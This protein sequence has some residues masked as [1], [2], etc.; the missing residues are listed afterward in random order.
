MSILTKAAQ[1][2]SRLRHGTPRFQGGFL[3][4]TRFDYRAEVGDGLDA[5][6]VM[7]PVAW[8]QRALPEATL[9]VR[10]KTRDGSVA[11]PDHPLIALIQTPN[12]HY[13]DIALW[14]GTIL[15]LLTDGNAYWMI[16]RNGAG[17]P[18]E[19]WYI[20]HWMIE[21]KWLVDG[22]EFISHYRYAPGGGAEPVAVSIDDVVH[23]RL[24]LNPRNMRKGLSPI[25]SVVREIFMDIESS[26]FVASLLRNMGV[27]GVV[28]SPKGGAMPTPDDV[29]A[30]KAWFAEQ[31]G[32]DKRGAPLVMGAPT[33]VSPFGFNPQQMNMGEARDIAEERVCALLGIPSAVVGFGAGLQSTKVGATMTE[34]RKLA[35]NN[36]VLPV[37]KAIADE[38]KRAML[39]QFGP[40]SMLEVVWDVSQVAALQED[41]AA[42]TTMWNTRVQGGWATIAQAKAACGMEVEPGDHIYLRPIAMIEVPASGVRPQPPVA[43]PKRIKDLDGMPHDHGPRATPEQ[44]RRGSAYA[45]ILQR[46]QAGQ[47]RAW[48]KPLTTL[49]ARIG[50]EAGA[51]FSGEQKDDADEGVVEAILSRLGIARWAG[52]LRSIYE[53]QYIE[54]AK[55]VSEAAASAGLGASLP[56]EV[57]RAIIA[58]GGRRAELVDIEGQSRE[59]LFE[60]LA[61]GRAAGEGAEQLA[62]RIVERVEGGPWSTSEIRARVIARTE[63]KYAQN[64]STIE[65]ARA[66]G[67]EKFMVFDGRLGPGRSKPDHIARNGSIVTADEADKMAAAEHPNGTL[68]FAP[69]FDDE[70]DA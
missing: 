67:V 9:T 47:A 8:V 61:E 17:R 20:P 48:E 70:D 28:I 10:R 15:S 4:R 43:E 68:S 39:W 14:W 2:L 31:F 37:A 5:S 30:T 18:A 21:P 45:L 60:A 35:W 54:I 26:N 13:G 58:A 22:S 55:A 46:A 56:D 19:L 53:A 7:A 65:R 64:V 41:E 34:M 69:Y 27:P 24:G 44:M 11:L 12:P 25:D 16:V 23:F 33:D 32:G 63:T 62:A 52:D 66:G 40:T 36:G 29:A 50:R 59:A 6:V 57:A 51:A 38:L 49:F 42:K 3:R 1:A